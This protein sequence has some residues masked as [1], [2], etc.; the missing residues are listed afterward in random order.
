MF[1]DIERTVSFL[2]MLSVGDEDVCVWCELCMSGMSHTSF[3]HPD[4]Q[5]LRVLVL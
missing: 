2:L 3:N 4:D 5:K 1:D